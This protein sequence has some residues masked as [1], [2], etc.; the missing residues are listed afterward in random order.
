M[1]GI[2]DDEL[3]ALREARAVVERVEVL[4]LF[5]EAGRQR[6]ARDLIVVVGVHRLAELDHDEV[7]H[8]DDVVDG[9]DAGALEALLH[10]LRRRANLDVLDDA[11]AE[12][13]AEVARLDANGDHVRRLGRI[14]LVANDGRPLRLVARQHRDF[15]HEAD[16][17]EAVAAVRRELELE[18]DVVEAEY[19]LGRHTDRRIRRQDVDAVLLLLRQ[20]REVEVE[21]A[22]RAEHAV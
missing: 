12:A 11:R 9:T 16:D 10:P 4:A 2:G 13:V 7:R 18:H 14:V 5:G 19:V 22:S 20:L 6:V 15:A 1:L 17:A 3:R 8:V 21:L